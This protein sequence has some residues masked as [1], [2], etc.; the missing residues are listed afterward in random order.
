[1][2]ALAAWAAACF[3]NALW[4]TALVFCAAFLAARLVRPAGAQA[5]HR[6]W[7]AALLLEVA[8]PFCRLHP[9]L[10]WQRLLTL[11]ATANTGGVTV[12][13]EAATV[14]EA[15]H[16]WLPGWMQLTLAALLLLALLGAALRLG[17][18]LSRTR[19]LLRRAEP[20]VPTE[21]L[22]QLL[23]SSAAALGVDRTQ[24]RVARLANLSDQTNLP[25]LHGP[26]TLG[27]RRHTL[28]LPA[29]LLES[30]SQDEQEELATALAHEMVHIRRRDFAWNLLYEV[31][32]LPIAWHPLLALT[33]GQ[34]NESR[35]LA[36]D[37]EAATLLAGN[38]SYA[39]SLVRLA[40]RMAAHPA[41]RPIQA[42]G[43]YDSNI[44]ER[45]IMNLMR[46]TEEVSWGR[47]SGAMAGC[48]VL[49]LA[50]SYTAM[51]LQ[52]N[53]NPP[54][55]TKS[56][57]EISKFGVASLGAAEAARNLVSKFAPVY[58]AE[59]KKAGIQ[60]TVTLH[61]VIDKDG[62]VKDLQAV[63][64]P[65]ELQQPA[66]DAVRQW[67][68]RPY[69]LDGKPVEVQTRIN[70]IYSLGGKAAEK[71]E[72]Q[73]NSEKPTGDALLTPP[74][75]IKSVEAIFPPEAKATHQEGVVEV[76]VK[77]DATGHPT[78]LGVEG[79]AL[80]WNAAKTAVEQYRF[81]PATKDGQPVETTLNIEVNFRFY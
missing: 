41:P 36:V 1:M 62:H 57:P 12:R 4:Q 80:F 7:V 81:Q 67:V 53:V 45:R 17:L 27:V 33:R 50:T 11:F 30:R 66:L 37:A 26:A 20:V 48:V 47:R 35:E 34:L 43:I 2:N 71:S 32:S 59:A 29:D 40:A 75:L 31:L 56:G 16:S 58:P 69:L 23:A 68:Y 78:V 18:S 8:L 63:S 70:V 3:L 38:R 25:N 73:A 64:G 6:V 46:K 52:T 44:F 55:E 5:E 51:A 76:K 19:A 14:A 39:R 49:A 60:G 28:L 13:M 79:P 61:A 15:S 21:E 22:E 24:V 9:Q 54:E 72:P 10:W 65:A 77:I 74:K 42:M